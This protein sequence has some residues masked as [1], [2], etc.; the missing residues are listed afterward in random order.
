[1]IIGLHDNGP[2]DV[3]P[4]GCSGVGGDGDMQSVSLSEETKEEGVGDD[5][6]ELPVEKV[7]DQQKFPS[8]PGKDVHM[9]V[10]TN[11]F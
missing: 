4:I 1:M 2:P 3:S 7:P 9:Q 5:G 11:R 8:T 10:S 6:R